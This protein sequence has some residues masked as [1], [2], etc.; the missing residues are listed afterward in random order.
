MT[1]ECHEICESITGGSVSSGRGINTGRLLRY[2]R[3]S[4]GTD[5]VNHITGKTA[6]PPHCYPQHLPHALRLHRI[7]SIC[8]LLDAA[9]HIA[10]TSGF[11][12]YF[13]IKIQ[14]LFK[15]F[16]GPILNGSLQHGQYY[17]NI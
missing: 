15:D 13:D 8:R 2:T 9:L 4:T 16:Q 11:P 7:R 5:T 14:G 6:R 17:N 3:R 10:Q 12:L 1:S